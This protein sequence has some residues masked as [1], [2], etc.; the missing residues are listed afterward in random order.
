MIW[1][2]KVVKT[3]TKFFLKL[4]LEHYPFLASFS[5]SE[6]GGLFPNFESTVNSH[7]D[8]HECFDS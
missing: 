5:F 7:L 3:M 1:L 8:R 4:T 6:I 2:M